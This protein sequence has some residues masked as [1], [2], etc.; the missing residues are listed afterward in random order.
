M[1]THYKILECNQKALFKR[2]EELYQKIEEYVTNNDSKKALVKT[3][4][5]RDGSLYQIY[6]PVSGQPK[7]DSGIIRL[8]S[9][10]SPA[11]EALC[12]SLQYRDMDMENVF[13]VHGFSNG[14]MIRE[15]LK[16][17]DGKRQVLVYE[18]IAEIFFN[19]LENYDI[20]DLLVNTNLRIVVEKINEISLQNQIFQ[21][22]FSVYDAKTTLI[23]LTHYDRIFPEG[24]E[25]LEK[26]FEKASY[27]ISV[28]KNTMKRF[29]DSMY[30]NQLY[31]FP[32]LKE[33][34]LIKDL[35]L[36]WEPDMPLVIV[37][38]GPSLDKNI[39]VLKTMKGHVPILCMDS[40]LAT[41][42][43]HD[44]KPDFYMSIESAK[45]LSLFDKEWLQGIPFLGDL[46]ATTE[47]VNSSVFEGKKIFCR[48]TSLVA[49]VFERL[50]L[51]TPKYSGG[52]NVGT[53]AFAVAAEIGVNTIIF[54]GH[55]HAYSASGEAHTK[56]RSEELKEGF[57]E[58][59]EDMV[60]GY[61]GGMVQSRYDWKIYLDW[62]E[63][64][65]P[66]LKDAVVINATEGG[67]KIAGT[68]E[69]PLKEVAKKYQEKQFDVEE[70]LSR[71]KSRF[72]E[73]MMKQIDEVS[74]D[75][76]NQLKQISVLARKGIDICN[77]IIRDLNQTGMLTQKS[78][79]LAGELIKMN[80]TMLQKEIY[81]FVEECRMA[82][83]SSEME[84]K[85]H[86]IDEETE[87]N[88]IMYQE[89]QTQYEQFL[90]VIKFLQKPINGYR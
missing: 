63:K 32:Y 55:D 45:P 34:F 43:K 76:Q 23:E 19:T 90:S 48:F 44:L 75:L 74:E 12:W 9:S 49:K 15:L 68:V 6:Q 7:G 42:Q 77:K 58:N 25:L 60:E 27:L 50:H 18:P 87:R 62:Y 24:E 54:V 61:G 20:S 31:H 11:N 35:E 17:A 10:Y 56:D 53:T 73:D 65:I 47:L 88:L 22:I 64:S 8:N 66:M 26:N 2:S 70:L 85:Y 86:S 16:Q 69:M 29:K 4:T 72:D 71:M 82:R 40:A 89:V 52:G 3:E 67:A 14:M 5:A 80:D 46:G 59:L 36:A 13:L 39:D 79:K 1:S 41:M 51:P 30:L 84:Y 21:L 28:N 57:V 38:A 81:S 33:Q 37:G 83:E 78:V